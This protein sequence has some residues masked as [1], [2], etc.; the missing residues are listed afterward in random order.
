MPLFTPIPMS[1]VNF[2]LTVQTSDEEREFH[3][4]IGIFEK[5]NDLTKAMEE[6]SLDDDEEFVNLTTEGFDELFEIDDDATTPESAEVM[7][8]EIILRHFL[9]HDFE[10][11]FTY[12]EE[13]T[14]KQFKTKVKKF[15]NDIPDIQKKYEPFGA[16]VI[17]PFVCA[18]G[19]PFVTVKACL[20]FNEEEFLT[21]LLD[22]HTFD[23]PMIEI[24]N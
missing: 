13:V 16:L 24:D 1:K 2:I 5:E 8:R 18:F 11:Y 14:L 17:Q 4:V 7:R 6:Y 3:S 12:G 23:Y 19:L 9:E 10:E 21:E 20:N 22:G 15:I